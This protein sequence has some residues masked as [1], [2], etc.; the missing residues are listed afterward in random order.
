MQLIRDL[1]HPFSWDCDTEC[2]KLTAALS[3]Q[4]A[5][6]LRR[7]NL[8]KLTR[9]RIKLGLQKE[10]QLFSLHCS[11]TNLFAVIEQEQLQH[12]NLKPDYFCKVQEKNIL[13]L[14]RPELHSTGL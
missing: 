12:W 10:E 6:C 3:C 4:S 2:D 1:K 7:V 13:Q 5:Q 8:A 9:Q 14:C 11:H